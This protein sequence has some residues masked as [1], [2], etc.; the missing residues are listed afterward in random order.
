MTS[1]SSAETNRDPGETMPTEDQIRAFNHL[2][3]IGEEA[4]LA[5]RGSFELEAAVNEFVESDT[6]SMA[7]GES[8]VRDLPLLSSQSRRRDV[9]Q[10][11]RLAIRFSETLVGFSEVLSYAANAWGMTVY[12]RFKDEGLIAVPAGA[13]I[14]FAGDFYN[15]HYRQPES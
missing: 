7:V 4:W 13:G 2:M 3:K 10:R 15:Q 12:G 14:S 11:A 9:D 8:L 5:G 1:P 6:F